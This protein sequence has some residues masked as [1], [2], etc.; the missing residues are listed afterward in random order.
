[1]RRSAEFAATIKHGCRSAHPDLVL[2]AHRATP[3]ASA[4]GPRVGLVVSKAV[5]NA[6]TRHRVSRQLRHVA[7]F[8]VDDLDPDVRLVIRARP[9]S[10]RASSA[11]ME[12][13]LRAALRRTAARPGSRP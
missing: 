7:R 2:H 9:G 10:H 11:A 4:P 1:M 13:Q 8:I 3:G 5:G 12:T 6:V